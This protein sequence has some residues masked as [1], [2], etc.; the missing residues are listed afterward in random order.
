MTINAVMDRGFKYFFN[1][2]T[3]NSDI[4]RVIFDTFG[5]LP[6]GTM[7][8]KWAFLKEQSDFST[9]SSSLPNR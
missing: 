5:A 8:T 9:N 6:K 4:A 7:P 1:I 2:G 3:L